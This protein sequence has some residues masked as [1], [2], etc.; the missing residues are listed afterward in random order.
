MLFNKLGDVSQHERKNLKLLLII[1]GLYT[2]GIYLSNVFVNIYLWKQSG[3]IS[4]LAVYNLFIYVTQTLIFI[5]IGRFVKRIDRVIILRLGILIISIF[6]ITVFLLSTNAAKYHYFLGIIIGTG[7]GLFWLAYNILVFEITEPPTRDYFNSKFG[8]LQSL[9]GMIG[10]MSA[11]AIISALE[12]Q[13]GYLIIFFTSFL[14]FIFAIIMSSFLDRRTAEGAY[15]IREVINERKNNKRWFYLLNA[16]FFQG[17]REGVF[18]FLVGIWVFMMTNSEWVIG[19]YNLIYAL[20]S[21]I[22]YQICA[23]FVTPI[24]RRVFILTGTIFLYVSV[25]WLL[26]ADKALD[27]YIYSAAIG[28][29]LPLFFSPY[30][31]VSYDVIGQAYNARDYRI[32][33]IILRDIT[34]NLGRIVSLLTFL[35]G[36]FIFNEPLWIKYGLLLYGFGYIVSGYFIHL[37]TKNN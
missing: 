6:F 27:F 18:L 2:L 33:Y 31:S 14:L 22:G 26:I 21:F 13:I 4:V 15:F 1:G 3:E 17:I 12:G 28:L 30:T 37:I 32:E 9:S 20:S 5:L 8:A 36:L 10:P 24:N 23:K 7:Y 34:L 29:F 11:G 19:V 16:H 25:F 35:L